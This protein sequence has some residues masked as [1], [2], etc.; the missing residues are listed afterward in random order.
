[1]MTDLVLANVVLAK[2]VLP[3]WQ[4]TGSLRIAQFGKLPPPRKK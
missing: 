2:L 1:M 3:Y 4:T